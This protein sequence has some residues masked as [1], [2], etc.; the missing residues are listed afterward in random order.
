MCR[1]N[2]YL[3]HLHARNKKVAA[4]LLTT[5]AF[6]LT[7]KAIFFPALRL[8]YSP[9]VARFKMSVFTATSMLEK[10]FEHAFNVLQ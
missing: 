3:R 6:V 5:N 4:C 9:T 10:Q 8:N 7:L 2:W 1:K